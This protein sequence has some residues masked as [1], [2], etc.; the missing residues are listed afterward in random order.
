VQRA[1]TFEKQG[2]DFVKKAKEAQKQI[3]KS[4]TVRARNY[5][6]NLK[7]AAT[8]Y[9]K[10][11][12]LVHGRKDDLSKTAT[13]EITKGLIDVLNNL[14][15]AYVDIG[16]LNRASALVKEILK[17]D[18]KNYDALSTKKEIAELKKK[19]RDESGGEGRWSISRPWRP[20]TRPP[21]PT[22]GR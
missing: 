6:S 18:P 4:V 20:A 17:L 16:S 9:R 15:R 22:P 1:R 8:A 12:A 2:A 5:R 3:R 7:R 21:I 14:A 11:R 19:P 10:A 13:N